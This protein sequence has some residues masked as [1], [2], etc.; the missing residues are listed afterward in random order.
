MA[1]TIEP[2][3]YNEDFV[4]AKNSEEREWSRFGI[5]RQFWEI[6]LSDFS[7]RQTD[8]GDKKLSSV[9]QKRWIKSF[10]SG[11]WIRNR[12]IVASSDPTDE[13]AL[14]LG[15]FLMKEMNRRGHNPAI[16]NLGEDVPWIQPKPKFIVFHNI[17]KT[18]TSERIEKARDLLLRFKWTCRFIVVAKETNPY[19]FCTTK[20]GLYPDVTFLVKDKVPQ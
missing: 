1:T 2:Q 5:P 16:I 19:K 14:G 20:L 3:K 15:S 12:V 6:E 13:A 18:A 7:F 17:L 8:L 11:K 10:L 9:A 4:L